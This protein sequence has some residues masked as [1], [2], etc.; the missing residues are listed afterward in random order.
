MITVS[1]IY[2]AKEVTDTKD[3]IW[4]TEPAMGEKLIKRLV[5]HAGLVF[6]QE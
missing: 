5:E 2:L 6:K 4:T 1:T 3:G